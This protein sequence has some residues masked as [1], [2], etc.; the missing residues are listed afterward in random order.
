MRTHDQALTGR[1]PRVSVIM[2]FLNAERYIAEAID[3]VLA[4]TEQSFELILVDDGSNEPCSSIARDYAARFHP[5]IR[6]MDHEGHR[7]RGM[8]ASRNA[9]LDVAAGDYV[10]FLD[11]DDYWAPNKLADQA[12]IM[13]AHPELGMVCGTTR[14]WNSWNG[15]T[16]QLVPSG[17]VQDR[18]VLPPDASLNVYPLGR[19][20]APC[21]SDLL[22]RKSV[23]A[24][25]DGF[26]EHF[27]GSK[28]MYEDQ[29]FLAKLFLA[30]PVWFSST[31]WL[32]YRQHA[33]SCVAEVRRQ[34]LYRDVRGYFLEWFQQYLDQP[35]DADAR[36]KAA[37]ARALWL[38]RNPAI[39]E[40]R[41]KLNKTLAKL[42][43]ARHK[44]QRK[45]ASLV[46]R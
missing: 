9:G 46:S 42:G 43:R 10:A 22:L 38:N 27:T 25:V 24:A 39:D 37:V 20:Y 14:Y 11:A 32:D 7:N 12:A 6:Y 1:A 36:V 35:V 23:V 21:P 17:H 19:A 34:G 26:E 2:I 31:V 16:D 4:Q 29:A 28:Q 40:A 13:D 15:G 18:V 5:Q 33:E 30:A 44:L 3:S 41:K 8:S 45:Y